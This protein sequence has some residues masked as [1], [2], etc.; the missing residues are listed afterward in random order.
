MGS[1]WRSGSSRVDSFVC[2][3]CGYI[4][5]PTAGRL[6]DEPRKAVLRT[7]P[8]SRTFDVR[9]SQKIDRQKMQLRPAVA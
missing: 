2:F 1:A 9:I 6:W 7:S 8:W 5:V 3:L 4:A